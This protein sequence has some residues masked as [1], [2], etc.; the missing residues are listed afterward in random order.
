MPL[1]GELAVVPDDVGR[2]VERGRDDFERRDR[3]GC[4]LQDASP[5]SAA[6]G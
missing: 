2:G 4:C 6:A 1:P 5:S 3:G